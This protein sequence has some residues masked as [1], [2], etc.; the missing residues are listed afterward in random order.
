MGHINVMVWGAGFM[1]AKWLQQLAGRQDLACV[2]IASRSPARAAAALA[3]AGIRGAQVY[4]GWERSMWAAGVDAVIVALPQ[5]HHPEA[6]EGALLSGWH[7]LVE[8]PLAIDWP[9][10]L[11][12]E[13]AV[14]RAPQKVV[15]VN[16]NFRWRAPV[17]ALRTIVGSG[18]LGPIE[19]VT[20]T[21]R[22]AIRRTTVDGWREQ[23][24][25]PFLLDFAIHHFDLLRYVL[26]DEPVSVCGRSFRPSWS[27]LAGHTAA[28]ADI[29]MASGT[30]V[31]Y[32]GTMVAT[33]LETAQ[34]GEIVVTGRD[35]S[36]LLDA[37]GHLSVADA[38]GTSAYPAPPLHTGELAY[39]LTEF[40]SGMREQRTVEVSV[41][42]HVR[43]LAIALGMIESGNTGRPVMMSARPHM[44]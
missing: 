14:A 26:H 20:H 18:R 5:A 41:A 1:A 27:W 30:T 9:G 23:M 34:E 24:A 11:R 15:M 6:V 19:Y 12:I 7:V 22:Q 40:V 16:Q 17:Q 13:T 42:E 10:V 33:G 3:A 36:A 43:S 8:K 2:G 21:C 32:S 38:S 28:L 29:V 35:G 39:A 37:D 31:A 25:E 4:E 44:D